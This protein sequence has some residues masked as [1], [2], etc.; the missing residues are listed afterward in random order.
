MISWMTSHGYTDVTPEGAC[1]V[2][3]AP[4]PLS[5]SIKLRVAGIC[6]DVCNWCYD[7]LKDVQS[8]GLATGALGT[9]M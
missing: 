3:D 2:V 9:I 7:G 4:W 1:K 6:Q 8:S 5:G